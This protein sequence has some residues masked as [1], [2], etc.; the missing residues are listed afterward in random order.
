MP[1]AMQ[2]R[3]EFFKS[4]M[5]SPLGGRDFFNALTLNGSA[6]L[7]ELHQLAAYVRVLTGCGTLILPH[8]EIDELFD[9][10]RRGLDRLWD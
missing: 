10:I 3:I 1:C 4:A 5:P 7:H 6:E 2:G 8:A 9:C